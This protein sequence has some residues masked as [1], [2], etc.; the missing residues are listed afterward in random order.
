MVNFGGALAHAKK[1]QKDK[2][3]KG[4]NRTPGGRKPNSSGQTKPQKEQA[5]NQ[6]EDWESDRAEKE[7]KEETRPNT[8]LGR[9]LDFI[10]P[11][12]VFLIVANAAMMGIGTFDF[13]TKDKEMEAIFEQVDEIFLII[14]TVEVS[15]ASIHYLRLDRIKKISG[16]GIEFQ[17]MARAEQ[18]ERRMNLPWI[19]FDA[20]VVIL[21]WSFNHLSIIRSFRILRAL[22]LV[23]KV[24]SMKVS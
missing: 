20:T 18:K 2:N 24:E 11:F 14:F 12:I 8:L 17:P 5:A 13:V 15:F 23:S 19:L 3:R 1:S 4:G 16:K 6:I 7:A 10:E 9:F 22:R 21:S